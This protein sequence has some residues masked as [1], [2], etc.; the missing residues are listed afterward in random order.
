M[1]VFCLFLLLFTIEKCILRQRVF[2]LE[3]MPVE[4]VLQIQKLSG[5]KWKNVF[6]E[7]ARRSVSA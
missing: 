1:L 6:Q 3:W 2:G 4:V 7:S 5:R